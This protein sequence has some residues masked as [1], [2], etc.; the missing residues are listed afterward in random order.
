AEDGRAACRPEVA[1]VGELH[2]TDRVVVV[3]RER[4]LDRTLGDEDLLNVDGVV[5]A[6]DRLREDELARAPQAGLGTAHGVRRIERVDPL[7]RLRERE[8]LELGLVHVDEA[9]A[10]LQA[11]RPRVLKG[12]RG[13]ELPLVGDRDTFG[14]RHSYTFVI[15]SISSWSVVPAPGAITLW[16]TGVKTFA[17]DAAR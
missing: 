10:G 4:D 14:V 11:D 6:G 5:D 8:V 17:R 7:E 12:E 3:R 1:D 16:R 13:G 15:R 2:A 9:M